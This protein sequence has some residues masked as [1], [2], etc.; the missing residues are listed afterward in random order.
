M[1]NRI[2]KW[3]MEEFSWQYENR[4]QKYADQLLHQSQLAGEAAAVTGSSYYMNHRV[5]LYSKI[6][7]L[8]ISLLKRGISELTTTRPL[9]ILVILQE[10]SMAS[11]RDFIVDFAGNEVGRFKDYHFYILHVNT[12]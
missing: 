5:N 1:V 10:K 12:R 9:A 3:D 6:P 2:T 4:F 11:Y 8:D 7:I